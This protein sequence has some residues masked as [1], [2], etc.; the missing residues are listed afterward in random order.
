MDAY[1]IAIA[2]SLLIYLV[3]GNLAGRKVKKLDDY[4]VAGRNAPTLLILGTLVASTIGTN[5]FLGDTHMAY[6][7]Y[8]SLIIASIPISVMGYLLGGLFFGRYLRRAGTRTVAEYFGRRFASRR[9]R[10]LAGVIVMLGVGGYLMTVNMGAALILSQVTDLTYIGSLVLVWFG[11]SAFTF[12]AGSQGVVITD[13]IMFL[14]FSVVG[15]VALSFIVGAAGGWFATVEG[16]AT[17]EPRP[18]ILGASTYTGADA[19]WSSPAEAWTW[20]LIFA[21]SWGIVFAISPWQSSRYLMAR[22]EHVVIR[23]ACITTLVLGLLWTVVYFSGAAIA[24]SN[25][26]IE[27]SPPM[28]WAALNIMPTIAGAILLAGILAAGLSS[29][30]TFLTLTGFAITNDVIQQSALDESRRLFLTRMTIFGVGFVA[31]AVALVAPPEIFWITT[32]IAQVFAASWGPVAF[33]S[34]WSK[35]VTEAGAFWG[36]AIGIVCCSVLKLIS[37][38]NVVTF[39]VYFDPILVSATVSFFTIIVVSHG[40]TIG[41]EERNYREMLHVAP[42]ELADRKQAR[43]TMIWPK[44]L[45]LWGITATV[46]LVV[47]YARPYQL[48]TGQLSVGGPWLVWSGELGLSLAIGGLYVFGG[49]I[50]Y[51]AV[52]RFYATGT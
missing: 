4:L 24:L 18:G 25:A 27:G 36:M 26:T 16:L 22:D 46:G 33:L 12:Y 32:F 8:A 10:V 50:A 13:T 19:N 5:S 17:F 52:R 23:S 38:L 49:L 11:Y 20:C 31:L 28:I 45:I 47:L 40:G 41:E 35:S 9:I 2:I 3:V 29:A 1:T 14:F 34:V 48:A 37:V 7:G 44:V 6:D 42:P 51:W 39:P 30:S 43:L 15:L 21:V